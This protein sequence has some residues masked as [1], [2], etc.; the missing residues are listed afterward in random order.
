M[1]NA[2]EQSSTSSHLKEQLWYNPFTDELLILI[3]YH[4]YEYISG[5]DSTFGKIDWIVSVFGYFVIGDC[6]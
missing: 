4:S 2:A 3:E 1:Q 5:P 6:E